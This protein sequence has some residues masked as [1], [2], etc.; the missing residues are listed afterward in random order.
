MTQGLYSS[1]G[2]VM[3]GKENYDKYREEDFGEIEKISDNK[4]GHLRRNFKQND[5]REGMKKINMAKAY[6]LGVLCGDGSLSRLSIPPHYMQFELSTTE[7]AFADY[8]AVKVR[9]AFN[10]EPKRYKIDRY[11][12]SPLVKGFY[13]YYIV[14]CNIQRIC[15]EVVQIMKKF[16]T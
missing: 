11:I 5:G 6:V 7:K 3:Y 14:R 13:K 2:L 4:K 8:F 12:N 9:S 15:R 16:G 10:I 1:D